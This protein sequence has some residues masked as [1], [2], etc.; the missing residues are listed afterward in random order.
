MTLTPL[1]AQAAA[2]AERPSAAAFQPAETGQALFQPSALDKQSSF[3]GTA[4]LPNPPAPTPDRSLVVSDAEKHNPGLVCSQDTTAS[5]AAV[6]SPRARS[7]ELELTSSPE[8]EATGV[9]REAAPFKS[10][11]AS[12][13]IAAAERANAAAANAIAESGT[14]PNST[15]PGAPA[16]PQRGRVGRA[17][18]KGVRTFTVSANPPPAQRASGPATSTA[19]ASNKHPNGAVA[20]GYA[21]TASDGPGVSGL[22]LAARPGLLAAGQANHAMLAASQAASMPMSQQQHLNGTAFITAMQQ[23]SPMSSTQGIFNGTAA[24]SA[25]QAA[26]GLPNPSHTLIGLGQQPAASL[27]IGPGQ[28]LQP[29]PNPNF[30]LS[31]PAPFQASSSPSFRGAA[32]PGSAASANPSFVLSSSASNPGMSGNPAAIQDPYAALGLSSSAPSPIVG[33][34]A[35]PQAPGYSLSPSYKPQG[36]RAAALEAGNQANS[37][38]AASQVTHPAIHS[39]PSLTH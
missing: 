14:L 26:A 28:S 12:S 1:T 30:R 25:A 11:S 19:A 33:Q 6:V 36:L 16:P 10:A 31:A 38:S 20:N 32:L 7:M 4:P 39:L 5:A 34:F 29:F 24:A 9:E 8:S 2:T 22:F 18:G 15:P 35:G 27:T 21:G 37:P 23:S 17:S 13:A 3:P